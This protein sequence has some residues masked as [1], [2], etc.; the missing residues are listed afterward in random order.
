V[1]LASYYNRLIAGA[2]ARGIAL[3]ALTAQSGIE[4]P[5]DRRCPHSLML[6]RAT[7]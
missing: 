7:F 4:S 5:T 1:E 6:M 3:T 2:R